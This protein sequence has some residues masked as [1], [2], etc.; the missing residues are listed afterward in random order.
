MEKIL[1]INLGATSTKMAVCDGDKVLLEKNIKYSGEDLKEFHDTWEQSDLRK[2]D[3]LK[4]VKESGVAIEDINIIISRGGNCR[5]IPGGI[6]Y[7]N[8]DMIADMKTEKWGVHPTC[9][10]C[11]IAVDLGKSLGIPVITMD[12]PITDEFEKLA[13]YSGLKEIERISSFHALSQKST[14]RKICK[15]KLN[16]NYEDLCLIVCHL[17]TG[18]SV[19]AHKFGKVIDGNNALDGDGPFSSE[20]A[21]SLPT[22]DLIRL[23]YSGKYTEKEMLRKI[24][25]AGGLVS[26]IGTNDG[27]ETENRINAGD[28]YAKEVFDA[29]IYQVAKE[30]GSMATVL[31]GK[32]DAIALTGSF[33]KY[34]YFVDEIKKRVSFI[35]PVFIDPGENE[36][37]ALKEGALRALR[38]QEIP[39]TYVREK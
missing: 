33:A 17:G 18:I 19:G 25:T 15:E 24:R 22:G 10:G 13:R 2:Q 1:I 11:G 30:V 38:K 20:R 34:T 35:A 7:I 27:F 12:P 5:P 9:V 8:E 32:V 26:Y 36:M 21:G 31:L 23:C 16:K 3:I 37:R 29:L 39:Q 28:V 4:A 14:A 6:Y